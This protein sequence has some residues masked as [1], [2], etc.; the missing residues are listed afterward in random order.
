MLS[1]NGRP[2]T[3][4]IQRPTTSCTYCGKAY[5]R[6]HSLNR[7]LVSC[8]VFLQT[9]KEPP[10]PTYV[11]QDMIKSLAT[12]HDQ[13]QQKVAT[14]EKEVEK[15]RHAALRQQQMFTQQPLPQTQQE[16]QPTQTQPIQPQLPPTITPETWLQQRTVQPEATVATWMQ[17]LQITEPILVRL[18]SAELL[19]V[20]ADLLATCDAFLA[21]TYQRHRVLYAFL[22][23][24]PAPVWKK[25]SLTTDEALFQKWFGQLQS[26]LLRFTMD[27]NKEHKARHQNNRMAMEPVNAMTDELVC[28]ITEQQTASPKFRQLLHAALLAHPPPDMIEFW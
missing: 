3:A 20:M 21:C 19:H 6:Q 16:G 25:V 24:Q 11:L 23:E 27:W 12:K 5:Q 10:E 18:R 28:K 13:L 8:P 7:H 14:L 22:D 2:P 17:R 15:W 1:H 4:R 9:Q 26:K